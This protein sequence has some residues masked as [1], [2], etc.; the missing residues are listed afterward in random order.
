MRKRDSTDKGRM[1]K[2]DLTDKKRMCK[3]DSTDKE[4]SGRVTNERSTVS[5]PST[6][7]F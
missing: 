6:H 7:S 3:H 4:R 1:H 5:P 2:H